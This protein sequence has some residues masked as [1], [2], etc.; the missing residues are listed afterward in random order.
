MFREGH[1]VKSAMERFR[2][3][4]LAA[5]SH[6]HSHSAFHQVC[7]QLK[8]QLTFLHSCSL[9]SMVMPRV[10]LTV[11]IGSSRSIHPPFIPLQ[12]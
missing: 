5:V 4:V 6:S 3:S 9:Q 2:Q 10:S 11:C 1:E 7:G 8:P 12:S